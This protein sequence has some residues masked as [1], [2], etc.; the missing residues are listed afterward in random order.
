MS[1]EIGNIQPKGPSSEQM[2]GMYRNSRRSEAGF[3]DIMSGAGRAVS[4]VAGIAGAFGVP[5]VGALSGLGGVGGSLG[6]D[7]DND[8]QKKMELLRLQK[9]IQ[10]QS[11]VY[12][13]Q[14]NVLK[15]GYDAR[16]AAVRNMKP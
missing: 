3:S 16:M 10:D 2:N 11:E 15:A 4:A 12:Q 1:A 8:F 13:A 9:Q 5:G 14:S 7:T 6:L